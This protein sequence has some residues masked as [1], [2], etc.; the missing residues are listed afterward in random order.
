MLIHPVDPY[1]LD[2]EGH[3][4]IVVTP[5]SRRWLSR[6]YGLGYFEDCGVWPVFGMD[7]KQPS[8]AIVN[9]LEVSTP[10]NDRV[11]TWARFFDF[12]HA[13]ILREVFR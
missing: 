13:E 1:R 8:A 4:M 3:Q 7:G 10:K 9:A 6:E 11:R 2:G 12:L 5:A